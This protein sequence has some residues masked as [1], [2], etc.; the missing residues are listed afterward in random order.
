M[1]EYTVKICDNGDKYW[2]LNGELHRVVEGVK[3]KLVEV[4]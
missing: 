2:Y 4:V 3:C 1:I